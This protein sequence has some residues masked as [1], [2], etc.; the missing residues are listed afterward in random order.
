MSRLWI[1]APL[2]ASGGG[3]GLIGMVTYV[4]HVL[5]QV[6][7][8]QP[9]DSP[10]AQQWAQIAI[11]GI[12]TIGGVLAVTTKLLQQ[13]ESGEG[14]LLRLIAAVGRAF[15]GEAVVIPSDQIGGAKAAPQPTGDSNA[16]PPN[17]QT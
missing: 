17:S 1:S 7:T 11:A 8:S 9:V 15:R 12:A 10:N 6:V 4:T 14:S 16:S 13:I 2:L 5:G 3:Y